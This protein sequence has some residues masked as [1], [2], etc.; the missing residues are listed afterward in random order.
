[1]KERRKTQKPENEKAH[2]ESRDAIWRAIRRRREFTVADLKKSC[3]LV[4]DAI[5]LYVRALT[6]A[7]Y[8]TRRPGPARPGPQSPDSAYRT[9][10]IYTLVK[11]AADAPRV[12]SDGTEI[13]Q[14]TARQH[15]WNTIR[16]RRVITVNDVV[17]LSSTSGYPIRR[18][19]AAEYIRY[20]E[21]AGYVRNIYAGAAVATYRLIRDTGLRAPMIQRVRQVWDPNLRRV[22]WPLPD[23][24]GKK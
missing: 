19:V 17:A 13:T 6:R 3:N 15:M 22:M 7:G 24:E 9:R 10:H 2:N 20:L 5:S 12:R 11:D 23:A 18:A 8:L 21:K 14:G 4:Y 16:A 1:M